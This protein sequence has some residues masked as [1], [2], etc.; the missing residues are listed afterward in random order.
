MELH[1]LLKYLVN[2]FETLGIQ[3]FITGSIASIF[4]GEPRFTNDI[5]LV[6]DIEEHRGFTKSAYAAR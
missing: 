1:V 5:D 6:A 3:Y 2:A 4:Y